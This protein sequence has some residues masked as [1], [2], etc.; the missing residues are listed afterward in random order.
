MKIIAFD[1]LTYVDGLMVRWHINFEAGGKPMMIKCL[2]AAM[3]C[4]I[5]VAAVATA[6]SAA[7]PTP[8]QTQT[9][10][11]VA[12]DTGIPYSSTQMPGPKAGGSTWIPS[13]QYQSAGSGETER[14]SFY[15]K[16][17]F[18]PKTH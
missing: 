16:K 15:S 10:P 18:G 2:K 7:D 6:A 3:L 11:Q 1:P 12:T 9:S 8:P 13:E 14:G 5:L 4:T 17:G